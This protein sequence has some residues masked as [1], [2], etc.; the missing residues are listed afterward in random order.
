MSPWILWALLAAIS[1]A[2]VTLCGRVGL[3]QV[4]TTLATTLRA[5]VMAGMLTTLAVVRGNLSLEKLTLTG[6][7]WW[8]ILAAGFCGAVSWLAYFAALRTGPAAAVA[9]ID[10]LSLPIIFVLGW[11]LLGEQPTG[12]GWLGIGFVLV[13]VYLMV[14]GHSTQPNR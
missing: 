11:L 12:R 8:W 3:A 9:A 6:R 5:I 4:D 1:A 7:G 14:A 2:G 10:R 13:G